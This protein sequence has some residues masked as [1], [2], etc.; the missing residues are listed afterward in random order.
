MG[1]VRESACIR[2]FGV[3]QNGW[4]YFGD[5]DDSPAAYH[6]K[7]QRLTTQGQIKA[8]AA[9][10]IYPAKAGISYARPITKSVC[11]SGTTSR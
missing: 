3:L 4:L 6:R 11:E 10:L 7:Q 1:R 8:I 2:L 5:S 9:E